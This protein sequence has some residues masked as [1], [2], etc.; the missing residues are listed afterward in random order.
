MSNSFINKLYD[1][2]M[3]S[4][5]FGGKIIGA[6]G[7]GYIMFILDPKKKKNFISKFSKFQLPTLEWNFSNYGTTLLSNTYK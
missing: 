3:K 6:G 2:G 1:Y 5:A 7:G 4:G